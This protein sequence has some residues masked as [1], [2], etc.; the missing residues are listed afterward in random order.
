MKLVLSLLNLRRKSQINRLVGQ[1]VDYLSG[2]S[3]VV[4]VL[5]GNTD[6]EAVGVLKHNLKRI[7][8]SSSSLFGQ[9]KLV[10]IVFKN[11]SQRSRRVKKPLV[12][13]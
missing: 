3:Y 13:L 6:E 12:V 1:V 2:Y 8:R 9:E 5:C 10:R 11:G 4:I 7:V